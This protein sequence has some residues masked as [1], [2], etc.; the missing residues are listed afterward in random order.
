LPIANWHLNAVNAGVDLFNSLT[1][2]PIGIWQ[3]AFGNLQM[4]C[5]L[6]LRVEVVHQFA[7]IKMIGLG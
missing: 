1:P 5:N 3:S 4:S 7:H 2:A 6:E